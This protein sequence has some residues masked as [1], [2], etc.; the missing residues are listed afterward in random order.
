MVALIPAAAVAFV[1]AWPA[2]RAPRASLDRRALA[3]IA[4]A[5]AAILFA[6]GSVPVVYRAVLFSFRGLL[7]VMAFAAAALL[8]R[9]L[10]TGPEAARRRAR[11]MLLL[12][13]TSVC[14]LV[15]F[16]FT[17]AIYF[18]YVAPLVALTAVA[19]CGYL[20]RPV[21]R[22]LPAL[23][24]AFCTAFAV[25]RLNPSPLNDMDTSFEPYPEIRPMRL[26]RAGLLVPL[27]QAGQYEATVDV[28]RQHARGEYIWASPDVPQLYFLSGYRN[29]TRSL[30]E[31]FDDT[32]GRSERVLRALEQHDVNLV[33]LNVSPPFSP[34]IP[35]AFYRELAR[36]YPNSAFVEPYLIK[37]RDEPPVRTQ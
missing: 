17:V 2:M 16:P 7:P 10:E 33:V 11:L 3:L 18:C 32:T 5:L 15:Q 8:P 4:F 35:L 1:A 37:W 21:P 26:D 34:R 31:F 23:V 27:W 24:V 19:F 6:S 29:P 25:L 14:M 22:A 20:D 13:V 30:F 36:R 12:G 28:V 9:D